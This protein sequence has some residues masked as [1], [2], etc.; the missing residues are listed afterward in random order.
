VEVEGDLFHIKW[1][2]QPD[3]VDT[4]EV[5][6]F[7]TEIY[8]LHGRC[9][10]LMDVSKSEIPTVKSRKYSAEWVMARDM[11][12]VPVAVYGLSYIK[13]AILSMQ[14]NAIKVL[15]KR[16]PVASYSASESEARAWL[17]EQRDNIRRR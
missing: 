7:A 13:R 10:L 6:D 4:Q 14:L 12:T 9:L 1:N 16:P 8:R 15:G 5:F 2:G 17:A 3:L 11:S